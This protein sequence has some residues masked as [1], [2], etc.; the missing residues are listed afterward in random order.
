MQNQI[1][2][3]QKTTKLSSLNKPERLEVTILIFGAFI[4]E[5]VGL[6]VN[7]DYN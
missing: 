1:V 5:I 4:D 3:I 2:K 7:H 6:W